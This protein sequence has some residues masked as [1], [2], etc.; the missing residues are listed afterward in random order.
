M[1]RTGLGELDL[2]KVVIKALEELVN[3]DENPNVPQN[4]ELLELVRKYGTKMGNLIHYLRN[5]WK[6][7]PSK[8]IIFSQVQFKKIIL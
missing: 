4:K 7:G 3:E 5:L 6:K 1:C 2:Q 8:V